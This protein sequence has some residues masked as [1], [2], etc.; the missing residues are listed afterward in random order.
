MYLLEFLRRRAFEAFSIHELHLALP[1][2]RFATAGD[3]TAAVE[4]F[5]D[6]GWV[7]PRPAEP[8]SGAGRPPSPKYTA[9]PSVLDPLV[10]FASPEVATQSTKSTE[11][12]VATDY[13]DCMDD[14][15]TSAGPCPDCA[16]AQQAGAAGCATCFQAGR[17]G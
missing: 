3:V 7:I 14:V 5:E 12:P 6:H 13:V 16:A 15:S 10:S 8:R 4:V 2:G 11:S 9:H 17:L 1:R